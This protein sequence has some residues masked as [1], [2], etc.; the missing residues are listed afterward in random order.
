MVFP[1]VISADTQ[2]VFD[3]I[4]QNIYKAGQDLY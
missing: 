1:V 3:M 4:W 2:V